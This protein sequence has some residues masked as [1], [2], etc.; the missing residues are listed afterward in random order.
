MDIKREYEWLIPLSSDLSINTV[1]VF[2]YKKV[3]Y[4]T[5]LKEKMKKGWKFVID[6]P[7]TLSTRNHHFLNLFSAIT[8]PVDEIF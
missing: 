4:T 5:C 3:M 8:L 6:K 2:T 1:I 7:L